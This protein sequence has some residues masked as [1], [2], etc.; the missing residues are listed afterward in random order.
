MC[1]KTKEEKLP[2]TGKHTLKEV[3]PDPDKPA[4]CEKD[5]EGTQECSVCGNKI[6]VTIPK[7]GHDWGE[8]KVTKAPTCTEKGIET[9]SCSRCKKEETREVEMKPHDLEETRTEPTCGTDGKVER[10]CKNCTYTESETLPA[11]GKHNLDG[12]TDWAD[13]PNNSEQQIGTC[14]VCGKQV[15]RLKPA[16]NPDENSGE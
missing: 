7:L 16:T 12:V 1:G 11:T 5:G 13:D 3:V 14:P 6:R 2:A 9:R 15:T 4:T 10:K 8:W